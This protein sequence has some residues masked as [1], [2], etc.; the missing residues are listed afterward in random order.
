[1]KLAYAGT[2][3]FA[4]LLMVSGAAHA[5]SAT[6]PKIEGTAAFCMVDAAK[7]NCSFADAAACEKE[8]NATTGTEKQPTCVAR[9]TLK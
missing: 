5:Q 6:Q 7:A 9:S 4:A 1:M 8:L 3:I 2:G